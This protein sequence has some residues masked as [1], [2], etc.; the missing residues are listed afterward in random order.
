VRLRILGTDLPGDSFCGRPISVA[1][2][3][4]KEFEGLT[5][6]GAGGA[7]FDV[8]LRL[9]GDGTPDD[10]RGPYVFGKKGDRFVY[11]AWVSPADG[12]GWEIVRRAKIR[13]RSSPPDTW[14]AA[15]GGDGVI[16]VTLP[17]TDCRGGP[18]CATVDDV[19]RW[20][21]VPD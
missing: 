19:C 8:D 13:P 9:V 15:T 14:A 17:L 3:R 6:G 18:L 11:L 1:V 2:Q 5:S 12:G 16:E 4:G 20:R 7:R 21:V 10:V